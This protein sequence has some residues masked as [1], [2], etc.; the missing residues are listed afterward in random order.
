[1]SAE[2]SLHK[3]DDYKSFLSISDNEISLQLLMERAFIQNAPF[4]RT[5][6]VS[7]AFEDPMDVRSSSPD[8][9]T[10]YLESDHV[11]TDTRMIL[12]VSWNLMTS[13]EPHTHN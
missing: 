9:D 1:M 5:I 13:R 8:S 11:E 12:R 7:G 2:F 6:I 3:A 4:Y 10:T